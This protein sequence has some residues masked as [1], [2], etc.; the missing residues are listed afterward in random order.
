MRGA[1]GQ[2]ACDVPSCGWQFRKV[3]KD[4]RYVLT[5]ADDGTICTGS[6]DPDICQLCD[7]W[8]V[9]VPPPHTQPVFVIQYSK[10]RTKGSHVY[11]MDMCVC[12]SVF[13][14]AYEVVYIVEKI[15]IMYSNFL[16]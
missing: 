10:Q 5:M 7:W 12:V 11:C 8:R 14:C 16:W 4:A 6:G 2:D 13:T 9:V 3:G 15:K 1:R